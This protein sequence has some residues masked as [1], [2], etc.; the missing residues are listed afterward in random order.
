MFNDKG[1]IFQWE[2]VTFQWVNDDNHLVLDQHA[3]SD[4]YRASS[5]K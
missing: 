3:E 5:L 4:F 2:Q 1:A